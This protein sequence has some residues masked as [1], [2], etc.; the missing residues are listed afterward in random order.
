M[1]MEAT[2][3][4]QNTFFMC[5]G[6]HHVNGLSK[7]ERFRDEIRIRGEIRDGDRH[8]TDRDKS[9]SPAT[10]RELHHERRPLAD[11][12]FD[13]DVGAHTTSELA[14]N[15]QA[16]PRPLD[17]PRERSVALRERLEDRFDE[18]WRDPSPSIGHR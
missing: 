11:H 5:G 15:R 6:D 12:T 16:K 4:S 7:L 2:E 1:R 17:Q 8:Q 3:C 10:S 14:T 13:L 9:G 18:R